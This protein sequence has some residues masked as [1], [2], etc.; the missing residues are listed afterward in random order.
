VTVA[1]SNGVERAGNA[2][3]N[4][5][6]T[7]TNASETVNAVITPSGSVPVA[8]VGC[9]TGVEVGTGIDVGVDVG[10]TVVDV[11]TGVSVATG[12][13]V[14]VGGTSVGVS[15]TTVGVLVC[16]GVGTGV[17]VGGAGTR[18]AVADSVVGTTVSG[19]IVEVVGGTCCSTAVALG[20]TA[21]VLADVGAVELDVQPDVTISMKK[22]NSGVSWVAREIL[23]DFLFTDPDPT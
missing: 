21:G 5:V 19:T 10:G 12:T 13:A 18:V 22:A 15:G 16:V 2:V 8:T 14:A 1:S 7:G 4:G 23:N 20:T 3:E 17:D 11:G 6:G 9:G